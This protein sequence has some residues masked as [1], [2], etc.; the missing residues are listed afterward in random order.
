M[1]L[2]KLPWT[3]NEIIV[4]GC[5]SLRCCLAGLLLILLLDFELWIVGI[6]KNHGCKIVKSIQQNQQVGINSKF[7]MNVVDFSIYSVIIQWPPWIWSKF[8]SSYACNVTISI[9]NIFDF[10]YVEPRDLIRRM[11]ICWVPWFAELVILGSRSCA[12]LSVHRNSILCL[13]STKKFYSS[14]QRHLKLQNISLVI[15]NGLS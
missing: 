11:I 15:N 2:H 1:P 3:V 4:P 14:V 6:Q 5:V 8:R 9:A 10:S 7:V 12:I 13:I